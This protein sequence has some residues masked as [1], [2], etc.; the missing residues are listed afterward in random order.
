MR[1]SWA[2][3]DA[4]EDAVGCRLR[5]ARRR[6]RCGDVLVPLHLLVPHLRRGETAGGGGQ[7]PQGPSARGAIKQA[8]GRAGLV[9]AACTTFLPQCSRG[10]RPARA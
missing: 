5:G 7:G 8:A 1:T 6:L 9:A 2:C 10:Y 4:A 3:G